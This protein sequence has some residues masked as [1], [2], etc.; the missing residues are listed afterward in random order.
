MYGCRVM[1]KRTFVAWPC[2]ARE[3]GEKDVS[4]WLLWNKCTQRCSPPRQIVVNHL[5]ELSRT[6]SQER[7]ASSW[8]TALP[9]ASHGL[10]LSKGEFRNAL[11]MR[12]GWTPA[13]IPTHCTD[14]E[15]FTVEHALS[16]TRVGYVALLHNELRDLFANSSEK[17]AAWTFP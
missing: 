6:L 17:P 16:C 1:P 11:C 3:R 9:L 8:L 10:S 5:E 15:P 13:Y 12:Y 14:G 7:G 4:N 2:S